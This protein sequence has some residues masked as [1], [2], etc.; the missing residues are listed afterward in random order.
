MW[1]ML[2]SQRAPR[3]LSTCWVSPEIGRSLCL[4]AVMLLA[5][6]ATMAGACSEAPNIT[7]RCF[8]CHRDAVAA[9]ELTARRRC[10]VPAG[11]A[12]IET[13]SKANR[14]APA[15]ASGAEGGSAITAG[16]CLCVYVAVGELQTPSCF[17]Q[18]VAPIRDGSEPSLTVCSDSGGEAP[19]GQSIKQ[20]LK[21]SKKTASQS[22]QAADAGSHSPLYLNTLKVLVSHLCHGCLYCCCCCCC[23]CGCCC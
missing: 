12:Q 16:V 23:C 9:P 1:M 18:Y 5:L 7:C 13:C 15:A 10:F 2:T 4:P 21:Q 8:L 14:C 22:S 3:Q 17:A 20:L 6:S 11:A 19:A